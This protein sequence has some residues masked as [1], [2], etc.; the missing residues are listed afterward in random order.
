MKTITSIVSR[1]S[2][3]LLTAW[4]LGA[5]MLA[6][7]SM[8][9][10]AAAAPPKKAAPQKVNAQEFWTQKAGK[11]GNV[12]LWVYRKFTGSPTQKKPVLFLVHGSSYSGQ[13]MFDL[14]V[15]G[16][17]DYSVMEFFARLGYD[18]WTMDHEGYGHS[19]RT[20]GYSTIA[21]GVVDL[22]AAMD[23]VTKTTGQTHAAFFGQSSGALRAASFA[24]AYPEA[25]DKLMLD[26][27]VWTGQGSPTLAKRKLLLPEMQKSNVR[28]INREFYASVFTRDEPGAAEPE[29]GNV[30][31]DIEMKFGDTVPNGTYVDMVTNLPVV[32]P[33]QIKCPVMI[34]R[35]EKDGIATDE[36]VVAFYS[37]LPN[38]DKQMVKMSGLAHTALLGINRHKLYHAMHAFMTMPERIPFH[39]KAAPESSAK[40]EGKASAQ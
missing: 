40:A 10:D 26:A 9:L 34:A 29:M 25:V 16:H 22:K 23:V 37:K 7:L 8:P 14:H 18:V 2:A 17:E 36:D 15:P 39:G 11:D 33:A 4:A 24:S 31:A 12:K 1:R 28:K 27:F 21:D 38:N 30:V 13:T 5:A 20:S 35:A 6:N 32:D 3:G 19:D